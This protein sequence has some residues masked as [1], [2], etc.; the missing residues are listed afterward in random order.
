MADEPVESTLGPA[1]VSPRL[2]PVG[3]RGGGGGR[4]RGR[5]GGERQSSRT[6]RRDTEEARRELQAEIDHGNQLLAKG[7]HHIHL[8]LIPGSGNLPDRI[9][10]CYP[11]AGGSGEERVMRTIRR[12]ELQQWLARLERLGGLLV[13]TER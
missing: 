9:A 3:E 13:D 6:L 8:D 4:G 10:V 11:A 1:N 12:W 7:G 2:P 5:Q